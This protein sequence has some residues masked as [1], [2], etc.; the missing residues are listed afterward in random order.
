[1][2]ISSNQLLSASIRAIQEQSADAVQWQQKISSGK[3]YSA[4]SEGMVALAR[5][6]EIAFD[7]SK[8]KMLKANQ[9]FVAGRVAMADSQ[10]GGMIDA[11]GVI[12]EAADGAVNG[13]LGA[14]GFLALAAKA[15][16]AYEALEQM[17]NAANA[18]DEKILLSSESS[19]R[20][21]QPQTRVTGPVF[22][23]TAAQISPEAVFE[24]PGEYHVDFDASGLA[25]LQIDG[26]G[27]DG[28]SD[29]YY[30]GSIS[31]TRLHF[32]QQEGRFYN[33]DFTLTGAPAA[34]SEIRFE[35]S[36]VQA[37]VSGTSRLH[38]DGLFQVELIKGDVF[39]NGSFEDPQGIQYSS[40]DTSGDDVT[41]AT[42]L[43][44]RADIGVGES[45][46]L[47]DNTS[48][49]LGYSV[50]LATSGPNGQTASGPT[51]TST[52]P[53]LLQAGDSVSFKWRATS[54]GQ[55]TAHAKLRNIDT[56][57]FIPLMSQ[58]GQEQPW[59]TFVSDS[60][61]PAQA[62]QYQ[63]VFEAG[64]SIT[65]SLQVENRIQGVPAAAPNPAVAEQVTLR[66]A[67]MAAGDILTLRQPGVGGAPDN[68]LTFT[69]NQAL[70]AAEVAQVF[71]GQT[72]SPYTLPATPNP[73]AS[74]GVF[75]P[76]SG[77]L[78][79]NTASA[80][81]AA[82]TFTDRGGIANVGDMVGSLE[83][84]TTLG[85][86]FLVD[87]VQTTSVGPQVTAGN[88]LR[89]GVVVSSVTAGAGLTY[90]SASQI[91]HL[92]FG[93][94][95]DPSGDFYSLGFDLVG[96]PSTLRSGDRLSL[97]VDAQ[98]RKIEIEPGVWV[99][100]GISFRE[101]LGTNQAPSK[102]VLLAARRLVEA[103]EL[104]SQTG[105]LQSDFSTLSSGLRA[106]SDQLE[107]AQVRAGLI[108]N[109]VDAAKAALEVKAT[110]LEAYRSKLL[111]TDI[112]EASAGL[113]RAQ[114]LLEAAR[115][116]FA[117]LESSNLFQRLM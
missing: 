7:Q 103:L 15:R 72:S 51:L 6:V 16:T 36:P 48:T 12:Q 77:S 29:T 21:S 44:W 28:T 81:G 110:E 27:P 95:S 90:D 49:T 67:A 98:V 93:D 75:T 18:S 60:I 117:R 42:M 111:D 114:T 66:F 113:V 91:T 59:T 17:A 82:L 63:I 68:V 76:V 100:E 109:R 19:L 57:E 35:V 3:Q 5:G 89:D 46:T 47:S 54:A 30:L 86:S 41:T 56:G 106:A 80:S 65:E 104:A 20:L 107:H 69:A 61:A 32:P 23:M 34:G 45:V 92:Q 96:D 52:D 53:V 62:G 31:G 50:A 97:T 11:M 13:T 102:D 101:A 37:S 10:L 4:A 78:D 108:G 85:A 105:S 58:Y 55:F 115:S 87:D 14:A 116:I 38:G 9:D 2:R 26:Q 94:A 43:G 71:Q 74:A 73:L 24:W 25:R 40:A 1:M 64:T 99:D 39:V 79:F 33:L 70:S 112:A 22:A 8:F 84:R 83:R 88:L